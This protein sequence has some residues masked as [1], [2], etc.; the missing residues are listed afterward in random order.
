MIFF[1]LSQMYLKNVN[2][3]ICFPSFVHP[4]SILPPLYQWCFRG[5]L[6]KGSKYHG[7]VTGAF[8]STNTSHTLSHTLSF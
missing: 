4:S 6:T 5:L 7:Q 1:I 2:K 3:E 8:Q